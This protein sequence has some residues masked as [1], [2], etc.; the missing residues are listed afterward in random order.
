[1]KIEYD[2]VRDLLYIWFSIPGE[3]AARTETVVPGVHA[4]FDRHGRLLGI[5][6]LDASAVLRQKVQFEV[7]LGPSQPEATPA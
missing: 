6:V 2:P 7:M 3:K 4:D 5:E 1:M